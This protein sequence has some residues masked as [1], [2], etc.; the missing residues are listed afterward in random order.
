MIARNNINTFEL[1]KFIKI[2]LL[3]LAV[4]IS[5]L[6]LY[7]SQRLV[8]KIAIEETKNME[9]WA[10][11]TRILSD[12][13]AQGDLGFHLK[14]IQSN[15]T[16]PAILVSEKGKIIQYINIGSGQQGYSDAELQERL[17][18]FQEENAPIRI[19]IDENVNYMVY[20]GKSS[21]LKQLEYYPYV[22]LGIVALFV[23][24][25]YSAF[26]YSTR[27]EQNQVWVGL[28]KETAHQLGTP[29]S[30]LMGWIACIENDI[31]PDNAAQEMTKDVDR[32]KIITERFS[33]IG[34]EPVLGEMD[35]NQVVRESLEYM[36][37]RIGSGVAFDWDIPQ[38]P[39]RV[40]MNINLFQWVI[41]NL[42]KNSVDAMEG[43]GK[44]QCFVES[45]GNKV[46]MDIVDTGKGI[47]RG[48]AKD[49]FKPGFTTKKRG[50]GLGLSLA[51]RIVEDYHNGLIY[52]KESVPF[53]RTVIRVQL[54]LMEGSK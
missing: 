25:S 18:G 52:V 39:L 35:F 15:E 43:A 50:W 24:V 5:I 14:I 28:A 47:L 36:E 7:L 40:M 37:S 19:P 22:I 21:V 38:E 53:K 23:L 9:I 54:N 8:N 2:I 3:L 41:E 4:L 16:I 45:K 42:V 12:P 27:S 46:Y 32:L 17:K 44:L 48:Q 10:M 29:I 11:A 6:T 13:E 33:K 30:S 20:Y 51:K 49:I 31:I 34:S 1:R 26:S